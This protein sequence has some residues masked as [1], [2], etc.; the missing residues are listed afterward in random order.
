MTRR[1][2]IAATLGAA[3]LALG[4][5]AS[6]APALTGPGVVRVTGIQN[7]FTRLDNGRRG[8]TPGD[9]EITRYRLFNKRVRQKPIGHAQLVC[10]VVGHSF[11]NCAG[12]YFLPAGKMTVSGA[13]Q[14]RALYDMAVT[15]GT[16]LYNNVRGTLVVTRRHSNPN[17]D[18]LLF[19]LVL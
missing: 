16:G 14:F 7:G 9:I 19:R 15:G 4:L 6:P 8:A 1:L 5:A 12:T 3:A 11:R 10:V 2:A 13:L 18:L 17:T